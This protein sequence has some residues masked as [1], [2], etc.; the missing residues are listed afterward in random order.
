M[1]QLTTLGVFVIEAMYCKALF[2]KLASPGGVVCFLFMSEQVFW[3]LDLHVWGQQVT[4]IL[5]LSAISYPPT[6]PNLDLCNIHKI[7]TV[8]LIVRTGLFYCPTTT[9]VTRDLSAV[10]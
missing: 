6:P 7:M 1:E 10:S 9:R 4:G 5:K 2:S 3:E 8:F